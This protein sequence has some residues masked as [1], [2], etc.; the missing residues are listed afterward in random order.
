MADAISQEGVGMKDHVSFPLSLDTR[1]EQIM[2]AELALLPEIEPKIFLSIPEQLQDLEKWFLA[3]AI[4]WR[5]WHVC[6]RIANRHERRAA[7]LRMA[8]SM[9]VTQEGT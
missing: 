7:L 4:W 5:K 8:R 3:R 6:D 1:Y 2:A 9:V